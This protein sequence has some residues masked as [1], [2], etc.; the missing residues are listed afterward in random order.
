MD[1]DFRNSKNSYEQ[2]NGIRFRGL[3]RNSQLEFGQ[4]AYEFRYPENRPVEIRND[5]F[6]DRLAY[7]F[8]AAHSCAGLTDK[9]GILNLP[10]LPCD[11][12][13][14]MWIQFPWHPLEKIRFESPTLKVS[15]KGLFKLRVAAGTENRHVITILARP[16]E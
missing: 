13:L 9:H 11:V 15:D 16:I 3:T 4:E 7:M 2:L 1:P 5:S 10:E 12:D 6:P 8:I 14:P